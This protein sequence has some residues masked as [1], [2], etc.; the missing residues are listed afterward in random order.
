MS[1]TAPG[2]VVHRHDQTG[3]V[4]SGRHAAGVCRVLRRVTMTKRVRLLGLILHGR[5]HHMQ[6]VLRWRRRC[7][8]GLRCRRILR[9]AR[10]APSAL[11]EDG[12]AF[13][14]RAGADSANPDTGPSAWGCAAHHRRCLRAKVVW[15]SRLWVTIREVSPTMV[16][17]D[18]SSRS[19]ERATTPSVEFSTGDHAKIGL[20]GPPWRETLR[21]NARAGHC[22]D[23]RAE[24]VQRRLLGEGADGAEKGHAQ[25]RF[26]RTAGR[27]D[28][29]PDRGNAV[30]DCTGPGLS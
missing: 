12:A 10:R 7:W 23:G 11:L 16:K 24:I 6:A 22:F 5:L 13:S 18:C 17:G 1:C 14:V 30:G 15:R 2:S 8:P 21:R 19:R 27:H 9:L 3:A 25:T 29:A 4:V 28:F 26:E 20:T